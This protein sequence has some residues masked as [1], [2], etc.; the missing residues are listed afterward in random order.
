M[1]NFPKGYVK[2]EVEFTR[3]EL[4]AFYDCPDRF[5]EEKEIYDVFHI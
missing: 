4:T 5:K 2:Q 1:I 3:E